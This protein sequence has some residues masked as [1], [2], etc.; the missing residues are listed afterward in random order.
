MTT[1]WEGFGSTKKWQLIQ[2]VRVEGIRADLDMT[3]WLRLK[4]YVRKKINE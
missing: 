3:H 4:G 2:S 1:C